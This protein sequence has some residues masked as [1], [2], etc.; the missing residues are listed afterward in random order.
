MA[1]TPNV[2]PFANL[3]VGCYSIHTTD[4][5]KYVKVSNGGMIKISGT[6]G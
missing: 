4:G 1:N 3:P 2:N 5:I 6:P